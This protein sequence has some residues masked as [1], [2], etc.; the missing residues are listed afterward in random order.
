MAYNWLAG[1]V[2]L[3]AAWKLIMCGFMRKRRSELLAKLD[4]RKDCHAI[5]ASTLYV[6]F[7]FLSRYAVDF[8]FLRSF[9]IPSISRILVKGGQF[10]C[11]ASK[12]YDD[13][14][15]L[16]EEL[17]LHHVDSPRGS[18][19]VRRINL[20]HSFY[21]SIHNADYIYVL[22]IIIFPALELAAMYG[23]REWTELEKCAL[24]N[25]WHDIG[26]RMGIQDIPSTITALSKYRDDYES[27][28]MVYAD[29]NHEI[30][31]LNMKLIL[32]KL[33]AFLR[34]L[35]R[36]L[37][38]SILDDKLLHSLGYPKQP[39]L[40]STLAHSLLRLHGLAVSWMPPRPLAC[41]QTRISYI[42]CP[43]HHDPNS[44]LPLAFQRYKPVHYE[45]GYRIEELGSL[46]PGTLGK[47]FQGDLLC[48]L[49]NCS[50]LSLLDVLSKSHVPKM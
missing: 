9:G 47:P 7:P 5:N 3:G 11:N 46:K 13:T 33:P 21:P 41:A 44:L 48:P 19:A 1:L 50:N 10:A 49:Q 32:G 17:A 24:Y 12:R 35:G 8:G 37:V 30:A 4:P 20:L 34:P 27:K 25:V 43:S 26:I 23:Y 15:I 28:Y 6:E 18:L 31:E 39:P 45:K 22:C 36:R 38:Y 2:L 42:G 29:S 14:A 16:L 40:L